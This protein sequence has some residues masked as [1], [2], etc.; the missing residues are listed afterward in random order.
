MQKI[1]TLGKSD[2]LRGLAIS[3]YFENEGLFQAADGIDI[4]SQI[5]LLQG[6]L[7]ASDLSGAVIA[8]NPA[9]M[10]IVSVNNANYLY[11]YGNAGKIYRLATLDDS[12][13][14]LK[15]TI[16]NSVGQG[17]ALL[18]GKILYVQNTQVGTITSPAA[19]SPT[20]TDNVGTGMTDSAIH[21]IWIGADKFAYIGDVDGVARFDGT[22]NFGAGNSALDVFT[23][24]SDYMVVA[25]VNDG[26]YSVIGARYNNSTSSTVG[27][28]TGKSQI[29]FWDMGANTPIRVWDLN[30]EVIRLF[31]KN[32]NTYILTPTGIFV[33]NINQSPELL[34][35][36]STIDLPTAVSANMELY[37][38]MLLVSGQTGELYT[39]GSPNIKL[40]KVFSAP[41]TGL[42]TIA[43]IR[44]WNNQNLSKIYVGAAT[45]KLYVLQTMNK[46]GVLAKTA[47]I[48]LKRTWRITAVKVF[49]E[50]LISGDSLTVDVYGDL[51]TAIISA[52]TFTFASDGAKST[53]F[54]NTLNTSV[55]NRTDEV[56]IQFTFTAGVVKV[57]RIELYGEPERE[58]FSQS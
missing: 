6:G 40:P 8:D 16:S 57:K 3:A 10:I 9:D 26:Y 36:D 14:A 39:Y 5:G 22:N 30:A 44:V 49:T 19:A 4:F 45:N 43:S 51:N 31:A 46:T 33:C 29:Y 34:V 15:A 42:G 18:N 21:P 27:V 54:I 55:D 53:K 25:G 50:P 2:W 11:A 13:L 24:P 37:R 35:D 41:A 52:Q 48:D 7:T 12:G 38:G 47:K 56:V 23:I 28:A 58:Y 32:G 20:F 1:L 17:L